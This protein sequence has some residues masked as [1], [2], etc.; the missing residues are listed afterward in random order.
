MIYDCEGNDMLFSV[1][2]DWYIMFEYI[3]EFMVWDN[4]EELEFEKFLYSLDSD[5]VG[6]LLGEYMLECGGMIWG[7]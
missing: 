4:I 1:K 5:N 6:L 7:V 3:L 2:F